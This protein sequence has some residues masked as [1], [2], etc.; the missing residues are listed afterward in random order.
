MAPVIRFV[1]VILTWLIICLA[2]AQAKVT[3]SIACSSLGIELELCQ[4]GANAWAK[5]TGNMVKLVSTPADANERLAL[6]QQ[7]LAAGSADMDVFQI[8]VVWPGTLASHFIDLKP[9]I[10]AAELND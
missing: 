10:P 9:Y 5:Q 4:Q 6:F 2:P 8:D 1:A 7:L 3:V